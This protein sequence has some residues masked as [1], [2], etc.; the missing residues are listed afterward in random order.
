MCNA[1]PRVNLFFLHSITCKQKLSQE[2]SGKCI[3]F[4]LSSL[5]KPSRNLHCMYTCPQFKTINRPMQIRCDLLH[6]LMS[7]VKTCEKIVR[8][9]LIESGKFSV[10][11]ARNCSL[12]LQTYR[13]VVQYQR[14]KWAPRGRNLK[15]W[16]YACNTWILR[17]IRF[18]SKSS[19]IFRCIPTEL[20]RVTLTCTAYVS[21]HPTSVF[22]DPFKYLNFLCRWIVCF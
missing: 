7:A 19:D 11:D 4:W 17:S 1:T 13:K 16:I 14:W 5:L 6:W 2:A 3:S 10:L 21:F 22:P 18:I 9:Y 8:F 12:Q 20:Y 15:E